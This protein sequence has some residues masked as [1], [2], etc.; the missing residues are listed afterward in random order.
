M[1]YLW[2]LLNLFVY[3]R[4]CCLLIFKYRRCRHLRC[5]WPLS[6]C[7]LRLHLWREWSDSL[8]HYKAAICLQHKGKYY[9]C[10]LS[11]LLKYYTDCCLFPHRTDIPTI[12][13]NSPSIF[14]IIH[15]VAM[16]SSSDKLKKRW[17]HRVQSTVPHPGGWSEGKD[18]CYWWRSQGVYSIRYVWPF[19]IS[20]SVF[21]VFLFPD[22]LPIR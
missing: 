21:C 6:L 16:E 20:Y 7:A 14:G 2:Y 11:L 22:S 1:I 17:H 4:W 13:C 10:L 12:K 3:L 5:M 19:C 18:Y 15:L 8:S 9:F